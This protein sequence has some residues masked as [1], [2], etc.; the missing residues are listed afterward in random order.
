MAEN[1]SAP[2]ESYTASISG[3]STATDNRGSKPQG[4][5]RDS[6]AI[7]G[8][9]VGGVFGLTLIMVLIYILF[10]AKRKKSDRPSVV[11][12]R[13][14]T[15]NGPSTQAYPPRSY[16]PSFAYY[17]PRQS[18]ASRGDDISLQSLRRSLSV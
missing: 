6:N 9:A 14:T 12:R 11:L 15:N 4:R 13:T 1:L 7:A 5:G 16:A 3:P 17:G 10:R 2:S 18:L 8:G